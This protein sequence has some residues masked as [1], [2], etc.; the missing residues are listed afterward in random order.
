MSILL[1][2]QDIDRALAASDRALCLLEGRVVMAGDSAA[3]DRDR[4][5]S[6]YFGAPSAAGAAATRT[7]PAPCL[8]ISRAAR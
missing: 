7:G 2:E 8:P 4:L 3:L 1:V 5:V 6:A